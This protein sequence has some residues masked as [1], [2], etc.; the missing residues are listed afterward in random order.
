MVEENYAED[1]TSLSERQL[2][3]V[4]QTVDP[5]T[6]LLGGWAVHLQAEQAE[7]LGA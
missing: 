3:S 6:C 4:F 2:E 5:P 1:I 7:C